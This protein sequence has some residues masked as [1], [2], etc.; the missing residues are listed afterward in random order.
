VHLV[1]Q[2][3]TVYLVHAVWSLARFA[4]KRRRRRHGGTPS[5]EERGDDREAM[6]NFKKEQKKKKWSDTGI[7]ITRAYVARITALPTHSPGATL[8]SLANR[9]A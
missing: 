1:I 7:V 3:R 9:A 6:G 4:R 2:G 8:T 5:G